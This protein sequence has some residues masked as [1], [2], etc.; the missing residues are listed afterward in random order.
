MVRANPSVKPRCNHERIQRYRPRKTTAL[1]ADVDV[2]DSREDRVGFSGCQMG[3]DVAVPSSSLAHPPAA[4][5]ERRKQPLPP[6]KPPK[7]TRAKHKKKHGCKSHARTHPNLSS[8]FPTTNLHIHTKS[9]TEHEHACNANR[10]FCQPYQ[11]EVC[12]WGRTRRTTN[13]HK[14]TLFCLNI[15]HGLA[16]LPLHRAAPMRQVRQ[17]VLGRLRLSR[18]GLPADQNRLA[19]MVRD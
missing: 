5:P 1:P 9:H 10:D 16:P 2:A 17:Q 8:L 4:G 14:S 6:K 13:M 12:R 18:P 11:G 7:I 15:G 3:R 19:A